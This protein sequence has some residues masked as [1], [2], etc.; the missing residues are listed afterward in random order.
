LE[1]DLKVEVAK[2]YNFSINSGLKPKN[3]VSPMNHIKDEIRNVKLNMKNLNL[4]NKI[5]PSNMKSNFNDT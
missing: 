1:K 3:I 5:L 4:N 2:D